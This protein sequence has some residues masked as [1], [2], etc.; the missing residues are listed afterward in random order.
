MS[1][2]FVSGRWLVVVLAL[3][4]AF[5]GMWAVEAMSIRQ[6][7][8][9]PHERGQI[10]GVSRL[11]QYGSAPVGAALGGAL[12][13]FTDGRAIFVGSGVA[14]LSTI[15]PIRVWLSEDAVTAAEAAVQP[16][17]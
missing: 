16:T 10:A 14:A 2:A 1:P 5:G 4:S 15:I 8:V 11:V 9:P 3:G 6:R 13:A 12:S 17:K 7:T